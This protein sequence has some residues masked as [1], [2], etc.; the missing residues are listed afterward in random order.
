[1]ESAGNDD[2][3]LARRHVLRTPFSTS[4][5]CS[6]ITFAL[7]SARKQTTAIFARIAPASRFLLPLPVRTGE[8]T[9]FTLPY[10]STHSCAEES[11]HP[12][13]DPVISFADD[14]RSVVTFARYPQKFGI[15][16]RSFIGSSREAYELIATDNKAPWVRHR[17]DYFMDQ[18][19]ENKLRIVKRGK[20]W[21]ISFHAHIRVYFVVR[22]FIMT[23]GTK[24]RERYNKR[25]Y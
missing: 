3:G 25:I 23:N 24:G 22:G 21:I 12:F 11:I 20:F 18:I 9:P 4:L 6:K 7:N 17:S 2:G 15:P 10:P 13:S 16:K 5:E 14:F 19:V 8:S 1:M